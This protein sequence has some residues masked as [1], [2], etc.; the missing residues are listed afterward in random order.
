MKLSLLGPPVGK[1]TMTHSDKWRER[2]CVLAYRAF[3]DRLRYKA[4]GKNSKQN[5]LGPTRLQ[6]K[7]FIADTNKQFKRKGPHTQKPD[8]SNILKA[9]ED[10][11][12]LNDQVIYS[13]ACVKEWANG[14]KERIEIEWYTEEG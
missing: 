12:F 2:E 5:L 3:C 6:V 7:C 10:A 13:S 11:L 4:Y 9:V 8:A 1:P 14:S